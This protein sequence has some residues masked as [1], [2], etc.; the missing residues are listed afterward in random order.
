MQKL[1][2][3]YF[4]VFLLFSNFTFNVFAQLKTDSLEQE[5][6]KTEI[7]SL[8][9][10]LM[11]D[12]CWDLKSTDGQKALEYGNKAL[13]LAIQTKKYKLQAIA[14]KNIGIIYLFTGDYKKSETYHLKA[15]DIFIS[16]DNSKGISS[17]NN[18]LGVIY[19]QKGEFIKAVEHFENSLAI[20]EKTNNKDGFA[21]SL[22]NIANIF[23][24]QGNYNQAIEYYIEVLKIREE[25]KDKSGIADVYN[26]IGA[27]NE[28]Q[29]EFDNA[30]KNYQKALILYTEVQNKLKLSNVLHNIGFVLSTQEQYTKALEY[31]FQALEIRKGFQAKKG[32]AA[33]TLSIGELYQVLEKRKQAYDYYIQ[34]LEIYK[35][36]DSKPGISFA[37]Y[38][39]GTYYKEINQYSEAIQ[40]FEKALIIAKELKLRLNIKQIYKEQSLVY[41]LWF[42][43]AKAYNYSLLY[44]QMKDSLTNEKNSNKIIELQ[45]QFE[46][47]KHQKEL[48]LET[49]IEKLNT[50]KELNRQK[51]INYLLF[52]GLSFLLIL[53]FIIFRAYRIKKKDNFQ[54]KEQK[55]QINEKNE[56]LLLYHEEIISQKENLQS[57][58]ELATTQL[59]EIAKKNQKINDSIQYASRIQQAL[60]PH[61]DIFSELFSDYFLF[62]KPKDIVSGDF[63]WLKA[64]KDKI[65]LAVADST[66]HGVPGAFMS[67]L[68]ISFLNEVVKESDNI[69]A[70]EILDKLRNLLKESLNRKGNKSENRDGIDIA[71][72]IIDKSAKEI[73]FAGAY[74]PLI[75]IREGE[76]NNQ[77]ELIE[78][79]GDK[80]PIGIHHKGK[81]FTNQI[82]K[83]TNTDKFYLFTDGYLDQFGGFDGRKFLINKF[84]KLLLEIHTFTMPEQKAKLLK[85]YED[86]KE[87]LEQIDDILI[88]GFKATSNN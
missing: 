30:L 74:N 40:Y 47:E 35:E 48:E 50:L 78:L 17:C 58:N 53:A 25:L 59:K 18:N 32:V 28:K 70:G 73:Q 19:D 36:I 49:Q 45:L 26:N 29:K 61:E 75:I 80:M 87:D 39:I 41:A 72:C 42:K 88:L 71:F 38:A 43:F 82:I 86:W 15:L 56:K 46:F 54:L 13:N 66:G 1:S 14:L 83:I 57:Q 23:Q 63:Y 5:L 37:Y 22:N 67:L 16:I 85:V 11:L 51:I 4:I 34:S 77:A 7:D 68:G 76:N 6:K 79:K 10:K 2:K 69:N 8:R 62:N 24:Q 64:I 52:G 44:E 55:D 20:D 3:F 60:L 33:T 21:N 65:F 81:K 27:L 12:I 84:K 9:I 31:Y